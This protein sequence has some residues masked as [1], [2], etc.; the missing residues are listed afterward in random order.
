MLKMTG[1]RIGLIEDIDALLLIE[2]NIRGGL[3]FVGQR[4]CKVG[5]EVCDATEAEK[6]PEAGVERKAEEEEDEWRG[7]PFGEYEDVE[8]DAEEDFSS[9]G[10]GTDT[11]AARH[12]HDTLFAQAQNSGGEKISDR[13][14]SDDDDDAEDESV[15]EKVRRFVDMIYIDANNL[16]GYVTS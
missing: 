11:H 16:Y 13:A 15:R 2:A 14:V 4:Y 8:P 1:V 5:W 10:D 12:F 6:K 9:I 7:C 3:S